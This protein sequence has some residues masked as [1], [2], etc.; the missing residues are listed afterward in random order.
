M[1]T[2]TRP[3]FFKILI[4][5]PYLKAPTQPLNELSLPIRDYYTMKDLSK[6]LG[7]RPD[8]LRYRFRSGYYPEAKRIN[9]KRSFSLQNL[10]A[11]VALS[12]NNSIHS[13]RKAKIDTGGG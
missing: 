2:V 1:E 4:S 7:V 5:P 10:K 8:A 13:D 9:G 12:Q 6:I 11:I 3:V